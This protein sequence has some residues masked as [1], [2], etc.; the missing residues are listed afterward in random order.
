MIKHLNFDLNNANHVASIKITKF[1]DT[2]EAD[3][4]VVYSSIDYPNGS[5][6]N[7]YGYEVAVSNEGLIVHKDAN[8]QMPSGGYVISG[9]GVM[10]K[11]VRSKLQIGQYIVLDKENLNLEVYENE[12]FS[13]CFEIMLLNDK[14]K[15]KVTE[16]T[17]SMYDFDIDRV[18]SLQEE[19][20]SMIEV[21]FSEYINY[22][23]KPVETKLSLIKD[24]AINIKALIKDINYLSHPNFKV[25][26]RFSWHRPNS[27]KGYDE[28]TLEGIQKMLDQIKKMGI[29]TLLVE[30]FWEGYVSYASKILPYQPQL[31][32]DDIIPNY[33]DY[34]QDYLKCIIG[35][36]HKRD[37]KIHAWTETFL[38]GIEGENQVGLAKHIKKEWLNVNYLGVAGEK[39]NHAILY[40]FDPAN[41]EVLC[42]LES[43]YI[44]LAKNY[45]LDGIE[46][47][48]IRYPYSNLAIYDSQNLSTL[49]DSGYTLF[50]MQDFLNQYSY[51]GD[52]KN[53]IKDSKEVRN[54]WINY[55]AQKVTDAVEKF[56]N[57]IIKEKPNMII[58]IAVAADYKSGYT[59]YCQNWPQWT[60]NGWID[61][62][63]PMVYTSD[64]AYVGN[65]TKIY[66]NLV[67]SKSLIYAGIGP[68]YF[69]YPIHHNQDQMTIA[70]LNGGA[71]SCIFATL[72]ILGNSEFERA[73]ELSVSY[74]SRISPEAD[75]Q[76][77]LEEGI[78]HILDKMMRIYNRNHEFNNLYMIIDLLK[79]IKDYKTYIYNDLIK[80]VERLN[81]VL[82]LLEITSNPI[83]KL[84]MT[85]DILYLQRLFDFY[86]F[87]LNK[88]L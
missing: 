81:Q 2:R 76:V 79:E 74:L 80:I 57:A 36:A 45:D 18:K 20:D 60:R 47:D 26:G 33:G 49:N 66:V 40:Y 59:S 72:N 16:L 87:K 3:N 6:T 11:M 19:V 38:A 10:D 86:I 88:V 30:T 5:L 31:K 65:L 63:K 54:N 24:I 37:I 34:G 84:R 25:E 64:T 13:I 85:E 21:I 62:V 14:T 4:L 82:I 58:T 48:Y 42:L 56:R 15:G 39:V 70:V 22:K 32:K 78:A 1:G 55:R 61:S 75:L 9:H 12:A 29:Q 73:L 71:G 52:L 28:Y 23:S 67:E 69:N 8:A 41:T 50:A 51:E 7:Q 43:A 46:L 27:C 77:I 44:E 68:V 83:I 53:L 17:D 35:E